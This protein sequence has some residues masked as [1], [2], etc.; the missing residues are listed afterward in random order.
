M[1]RI[2]PFINFSKKKMLMNYFFKSQFSYCPLVR[3]CHSRTINNKINHLHERCLRV[4]YNDKFS[5]FT[6]LLE[7]NGSVPLHNR[8][9]WILATEMFKVYNNITP[10]ILTEIFNKWNPNYQLRHMSHFLAP[11][12]R[13]VYTLESR[14]IEGVGIIGGIGHCNSC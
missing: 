12:V 10:P 9:L 7:K 11:P 8:N 2:T 14:I 5:S 1:S 3:M 4:F 13:S 6:E